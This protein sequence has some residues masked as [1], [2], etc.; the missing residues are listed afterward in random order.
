[1]ATSL[2]DL[3]AFVDH[4]VYVANEYEALGTTVVNAFYPN[5]HT[6]TSPAG[7]ESVAGQFMAGLMCGG[8]ALSAYSTVSLPSSCV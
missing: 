6:H 7:A 5:D 3:A 8:S 2:G 1:M 4:G